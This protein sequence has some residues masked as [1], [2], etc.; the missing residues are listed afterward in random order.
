MMSQMMWADLTVCDF[1]GGYNWLGEA[2]Q[3]PSREVSDDAESEPNFL[4]GLSVAEFFQRGNWQ[5]KASVPKPRLRAGVVKKLSLSMPVAEFLGGIDWQGQFA[6]ANLE[7][8]K[9]PVATT[10]DLKL[11]QLSDLF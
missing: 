10:Q 4:L 6:I 5:G 9:P 8:P 3:L 1:F 7:S 2:P 11:N